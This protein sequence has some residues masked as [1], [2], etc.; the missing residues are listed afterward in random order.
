MLWACALR[1]KV[2]HFH[3]MA[4][5]G[6]SGDRALLQDR[7]LRCKEC[8]SAFVFTVG[9]QEFYLTKGL[10][11]APQ[12]CSG[13]RSRGK[14]AEGSSRRAAVPWTRKDTGGAR[15]KEHGGDAGSE[16]ARRQMTDIRCVQCGETAQVPF[17]PRE[18]RPVYCRACYAAVRGVAGSEAL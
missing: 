15:V 9:E 2:F 10:R 12:R 14:V 3:G 18:N 5:D 1:P 11:H 4:P 13:C 7:E 6:G 8:G 17:Q 16:W